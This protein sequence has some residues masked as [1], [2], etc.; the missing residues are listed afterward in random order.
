MI[1]RTFS[2]LRALI[3][4]NP[5]KKWVFYQSKSLDGKPN[6][7]K[8]KKVFDRYWTG[9]WPSAHLQEVDCIAYWDSTFGLLYVGKPSTAN[10]RLIGDRWKVPFDSVK[11]YKV[12]DFSLKRTT[13]M[14]LLRDERKGLANIFSYWPKTAKEYEKQQKGLDQS[15]P[16]KQQA[17]S[18]VEALKLAKE[19]RASDADELVKN[20][21]LREIWCRT[22]AHDQFRKKLLT[23]WNEKCA[24]TGIGGNSLMVAS[25]IK[26][27]ATCRDEPKLQTDI[28]NGLILC[29]PID[30]LFDRGYLTFN[31][32]GSVELHKEEGHARWLGEESLA[33]FGL[34]TAKLPEI[35][36]PLTAKTKEFLKYHRDNVFNRV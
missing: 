26:P 1:S 30:K 13:L 12:T 10:N 8:D 23:E 33:V 19:V 18:D 21:I 17:L 34:N 7:T 32:D 20:E 4:E 3:R 24:L 14:A 11:I 31:D 5:T 25:H 6:F 35:K 28:N 27:W 16:R 22:Q 29:T 9:N 15:S 2:D 36:Q